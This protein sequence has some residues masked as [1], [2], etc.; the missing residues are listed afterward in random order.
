MS[1]A[2]VA[3]S[4]LDSGFM[5]ELLGVSKRYGGLAAVETLDLTVPAGRTLA[6][7][8]PSG[9]GKST[10]LRLMIGL[11]PPD[12]GAVRFRGRDIVG[13]DALTI[14]REYGYVIQ[15]GGLFPHLTGL[16]NVALLARY[17]GWPAEKI[18]HRV[19]E[20]RGLTHLPASAL[21]RFPHQLSGGQQQRVALMRALMLDPFVLLL[22]EPLGALDPM[23]RA[24]LQRDL[25]QAFQSLG[26]TVVV[27]TH[28]VNEAA[29]L[30]DDLLLLRKGRVVQHA[31]I[32]D[33]VQRPSD[34]F[35]TEFLRAQRRPL[36][37]FF[38]SPPCDG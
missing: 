10:L 29:Y 2:H 14:R 17:L 8:G 37:S 35:V 12:S 19:E 18:S 6:V 23:I 21:E 22:D 7:I 13:P 25:K 1:S 4:A 32:E 30:A 16:D 31:S 38:D 20:L 15:D 33:F 9:C 3:M 5:L 26:K 24:E 28:D 36:D 11:I 34:E 27:V